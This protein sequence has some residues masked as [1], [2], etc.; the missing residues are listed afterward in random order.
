MARYAEDIDSAASGLAALPLLVAGFF[1]AKIYGARLAKKGLP[2]ELASQKIR[3][4]RRLTSGVVF[5]ICILLFERFAAPF[6]GAIV[7]TAFY[8]LGGFFG[9]MHVVFKD[10][11]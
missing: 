3:L 9:E 6:L 4:F 1:L 10:K 2:E 5:F 8:Y 11:K 7:A